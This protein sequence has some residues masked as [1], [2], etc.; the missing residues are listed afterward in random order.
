METTYGIGYFCTKCGRVMNEVT[1]NYQKVEGRERPKICG[2][3]GGQEF[4]M[5]IIEKTTDAEMIDSMKLESRM[6]NDNIE[7]N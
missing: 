5:G 1:T 3:C 4:E 7:A 2:K 6:L